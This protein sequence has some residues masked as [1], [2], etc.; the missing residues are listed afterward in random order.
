[1]FLREYHRTKD[2]KRHTYFALVESQRTERGPRQ[3]I[4][5]Q[6]GELTRDQQRCWRRTAIF[7]GRHTE[8]DRQTSRPRREGPD[9][10][11]KGGELPLFVDEGP[12]PLP[13]DPEVVRIH[14]R[15]VGWCQASIIRP[16]RRRLFFPSS[17]AN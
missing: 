12:A 9:G 16:S 6:L 15:K 14:L 2:G 4:V 3:R 5:A 10:S 13:D 1:M 8:S 11:P 17:S 7:H